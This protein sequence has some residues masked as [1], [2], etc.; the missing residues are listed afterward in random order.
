MP[1]SPLN[2]ELGVEKK[3]KAERHPFQFIQSQHS[4]VDEIVSSCSFFQLFMGRAQRFPEAQIPKCKL[5]VYNNSLPY[6]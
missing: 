4:L 6:K 5:D 2:V 1:F 3:I